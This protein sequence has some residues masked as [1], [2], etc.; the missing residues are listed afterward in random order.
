MSRYNRP[1]QI[2]NSRN[3]IQIKDAE[4]FKGILQEESEVQEK[5]SIS[6]VTD[7]KTKKVKRDVPESKEPTIIIPHM[8]LVHLHDRPLLPT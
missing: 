6:H 1:R 4:E 2:D 3:L 5:V 7:V 8:S